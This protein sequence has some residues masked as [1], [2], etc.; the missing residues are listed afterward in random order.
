MK[1][2]RWIFSIWGLISTHRVYNSRPYSL[3]TK[4]CFK[5][6]CKSKIVLHAS[7]HN[8]SKEK[9]GIPTD[10][11]GTLLSIQDPKKVALLV[12][13]GLDI[14]SSDDISIRTGAQL[15]KERKL[16]T[17]K[18]NVKK[19]VGTD[20]KLQSTAINSRFRLGNGVEAINQSKL[21]EL[22]K[23]TAPYLFP[24]LSPKLVLDEEEEESENFITSSLDSPTI[25]QSS[26]SSSPIVSGALNRSSSSMGWM[27]ILQDMSSDKSYLSQD[28]SAPTPA[29]RIDYF[30]L[31]LA[32]HFATVAT[33][34]PTDVDSKIRGHCWQDPDPAV[35]AAQF[36]LTKQFAGWEVGGVSRRVLRVIPDDSQES[37][38][39]ISG[40]D[41][42]WLGTMMGA[43][44]AFLRTGDSMRAQEACELVASEL[45][46]EAKA[47]RYL[48]SLP[49]SP[50][51]DTVL[52]KLAAVMTH[53]VGDV[54][55]GLSY[56]LDSDHSNNNNNDNNN[57]RNSDRDV[58]VSAVM[59]LPP[60]TREMYLRF[61][62]LAH[63]RYERFGGEFGR[64]K[65]LYKQLLSAEGHRN[66]PLREARCLRITPDL[67]LPLAPWLESW[68]RAV[69]TH[70]S[71]SVEDRT[72]VV[73]QL[74]RGC[75]DTSKAWGVPNQ[76]GYYRALYGMQSCGSL[77]GLTKYLD[78]D[79]RA[80]LKTH[81][82]RLHLGLSDISFATK[83]GRHAREL[84][85]SS[86]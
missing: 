51:V 10:G 27:N 86:S 33:F 69:A 13:L 1:L 54:D 70:P 64:A 16:T 74:L 14:S 37:Q 78:K 55:Q 76:V 81:T 72:A 38:R 22:V 61:S 45:A 4:Y 73:R 2:N 56:W 80:L 44:G 75:D 68:G 57:N 17:T 58:D 84:L 20:L 28:M 21:L 31:C 82:T 9:R 42:E 11:G 67:M 8:A 83:L 47:F 24:E 34:V 19:R 79:C 7:K 52:L 59:S 39:P 49:S 12:K 6:K 46:R 43:M 66:Y 30:A 65:L 36:E 77:E 5:S 23:S 63:E 48:R 40:H 71:L 60:A 3:S 62:R 32:S 50:G 18:T 53:N 35:L 15:R 29:Q 41:G 25:D 26:K 85:D